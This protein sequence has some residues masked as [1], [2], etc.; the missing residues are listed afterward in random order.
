MLRSTQLIRH[1]ISR[2]IRVEVLPSR[3]TS[4]SEFNSFLSNLHLFRND[5]RYSSGAFDFSTLERLSSIC[6]TE[7]NVDMLKV[8]LDTVRILSGELGKDFSDD[9]FTIYRYILY[10]KNKNLLSFL[11]S[12]Y[13]RFNCTDILF[14]RNVKYVIPYLD[15]E[16]IT[17]LTSNFLTVE[18]PKDKALIDNILYVFELLYLY[19]N[20]KVRN[21]VISYLNKN[22][23]DSDSIRPY[24]F[25]G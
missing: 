16:E 14:N 13:K 20:K 10:S 12:Y 22:G 15:K 24:N 21:D 3:T 9:F 2:K 8:L 7:D 23:L 19:G 5:D 6:F 17:T 25:K 1:V 4:K 11:F 18:V